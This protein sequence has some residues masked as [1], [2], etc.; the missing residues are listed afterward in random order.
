MKNAPTGSGR[1]AVVNALEFQLPQHPQL[2]RPRH[3]LRA[4]FNTKLAV[5][6]AGM[7]FHRVQRNKQLIA[8]LLI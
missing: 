1:F 7:G 5:D 4:P 2:L 8:D 3:R 6:M